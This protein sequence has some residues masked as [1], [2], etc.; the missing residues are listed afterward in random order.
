MNNVSASNKAH[1]VVIGAG[2]A[3]L[4]AA[5]RLLAAGA[6]VTLVDR[7]KGP[8][9]RATT[10]EHDGFFLNQGPHALYVGGA[11]YK[12][13]NELGIAPA[14]SQPKPKRSMLFKAGRE[15][16]M[17]ISPGTILSTNIFSV[18]EKVE[19]TALMVTL[20]RCDL[21]SLKSVSLDDWLAKEV[22]SENVRDVFKAMVRLSTYSNCSSLFSAAAAIRQLLLVQTDGVIYLDHG[23]Q[24]IVDAMHSLV[25]GKAVEIYEADVSAVRPTKNGVEVVINGEIRRFDA[26]I[27]ALP[28]RVAVKLLEGALP[29]EDATE[30]D[31]IH[32]IHAACLD[33][34]LKNLPV[35]DN[36]FGIGVDVP[37]YYSVHSTTAKLTE[38]GH[39]VHLAYYL[40]E[41]EKGDARHERILL[42][43]MDRIQPDWREALVY[44]R[45]MPNLV[46]SYGTALAAK[47]GTSGLADVTL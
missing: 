21:A 11:G 6:A 2:M 4:T 1:I 7:A 8:G 35:A 29:L 40:K 19:W 3:G 45:Y 28:P 16:D 9:G 32:A 34:C 5:Q 14:G 46:S 36:T 42:D 31:G 26:A 27:L 30:I 12:I 41:G 38:F 18:G 24:S 13:F 37:T 33:I 10:L 44:K 25:E 20:G 47:N 43:L 23:W 17:P 15:Y 39:V 22:K